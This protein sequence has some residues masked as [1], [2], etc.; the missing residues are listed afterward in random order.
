MPLGFTPVLLEQLRTCTWTRF[1]EYLGENGSSPGDIKRF[2]SAE[3]AAAL[4]EEHGILSTSG[5]GY[6]GL[7]D[8]SVLGRLQEEGVPEP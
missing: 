7:R 3:L 8:L 2:S 4:A 1:L 6:E 5:E